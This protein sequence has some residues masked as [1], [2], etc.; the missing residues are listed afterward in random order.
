MCPQNV[1]LPISY[2]ALFNKNIF[3]HFENKIDMGSVFNACDHTK[4]WSLTLTP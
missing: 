4:N 2:L 3:L 1:N